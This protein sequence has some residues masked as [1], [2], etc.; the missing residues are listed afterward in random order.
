MGRKLTGDWRG[1]QKLAIKRGPATV[2]RED[3]LDYMTFQRPLA[4]LFTEIFGPLV[5]LPEEWKAQGA[6]AEELDFSAFPYRRHASGGVGVDTGFI[7]DLFEEE[8]LEETEESIVYRDRMGRLMKFPKGYATIPLPLEYPVKNM[9]DWLKFK[10][11]YEFSEARFHPGWEERARALV[12]QGAVVVFGM[13]GGF[14]T[15]RELMGDEEVCVAYYEQPELIHDMLKTFGDAVERVWRRVVQVVPVDE[16]T[17]HEDMA[18]K[19]GPLAGPKQ[20]REFIG[21]YYR[22]IWNGSFRPWSGSAGITLLST[23]AC[24][25][26]RRWQPTD[27]T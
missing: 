1:H 21:P 2:S 10:P 22:R 9:D 12:A 11:H 7:G 26:E 5:G 23:T 4:P 24:R 3:Y 19:S 15:P 25:T 20:I 8:V 6:T 27:S 13:P 14:S 16:L 17:V 18:G